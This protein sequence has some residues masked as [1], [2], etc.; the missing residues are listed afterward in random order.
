MVARRSI[1]SRRGMTSAP[2]AL[3]MGLVQTAKMTRD[4]SRGLS[5]ECRAAFS[6][7]PPGPRRYRGCGRQ[8][9]SVPIV[10]FSRTSKAGGGH[11]RATCRN[12]P[13]RLEETRISVEFRAWM[14]Y[15]MYAC[16]FRSQPLNGEKRPG[17]TEMHGRAAAG[18]GSFGARG[19]LPV[20]LVRSFESSI[21]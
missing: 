16:G 12:R 5:G 19:E 11:A 1:P 14:V 20:L 8:A 9:V 13:K 15:I 2:R 18:S 21:H 4:R 6:V 7:T 10:A 3:D 17:A